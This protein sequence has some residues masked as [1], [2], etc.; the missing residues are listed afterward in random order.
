M[1]IPASGTPDRKSWIVLFLLAVIILAGGFLRLSALTGSYVYMPI[2]GDAASYF[3]YAI[4][5]NTEQ[6]YSRSPPVAL[7]SQKAIQPDAD[8][9]P[10]F[11]LFVAATLSGDWQ[12]RTH[13]GVEASIRPTLFLQTGLSIAV[14][15]LGFLA[16]R[17]IGG[18]TAGLV[19]ALLIALSPH[20]VN[21]NIYLLTEPTFALL[22]VT[23]CL[24]TFYWLDS[25]SPWSPLLPALAGTSLGLS[26]LTREAVT[27][28]PY[29]VAFFSIVAIR[30]PW[31][32]AAIYVVAFLLVTGAWAVR[33]HV[34][35]P[36]P[37]NFSPLVNTIQHGSYPDFM[38][39]GQRESQG[40]PYS[41][42]KELPQQKTLAGTLRIIGARIQQ[43]PAT[44]LH[45]YLVGKPV[46]LFTWT[47]LPVGVHDSRLLTS[48]DIFIYPTL[49]SP[50]ENRTPHRL[51]YFLMYLMYLPCLVL[52]FAAFILSW[53]QLGHRL[54][55]GTTPLVQL[56]GL[57]LLYAIGIHMIGAPFP[58]YA[59][60]FLPL[61][62][63]LAA[64]L[65]VRLPALAR[66][67]RLMLA[68]LRG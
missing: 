51:S 32:E 50:Y 39:N 31:R 14:I 19:C 24:L 62:Y 60:P 58:R 42:D 41:F 7:G 68:P 54:W 30:R 4:N 48:G 40:V 56:T 10:V 11:P 20:L 65:A 5:L 52:A 36:A 2:R 26:A 38:Y 63:L 34:S 21:I 66:E 44:Y 61:V 53:T 64:A 9:V 18:T 46:S 33:N 16:G 22:F 67:I 15:V 8:V 13:G 23:A 45:W 57:I 35:V 59:I 37:G 3:Y 6:V 28:L 49:E 12:L 47:P 1:D 43:D 17:R 27:Y 25:R 55:Q 29:L